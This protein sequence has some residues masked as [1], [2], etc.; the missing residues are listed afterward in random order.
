MTTIEINPARATC[1]RCYKYIY[2]RIY[3]SDNHDFTY[4]EDCG[5]DEEDV[6]LMDYELEDIEV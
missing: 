5:F 1:A 3:S 4:C 2:D 6:E